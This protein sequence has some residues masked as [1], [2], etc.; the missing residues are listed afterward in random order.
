MF[1]T[2]GFTSVQRDPKVASHDVAAER[3]MGVV[4]AKRGDVRPLPSLPD[5]VVPQRFEHRAH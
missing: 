2:L 3:C 5:V 1:T 4:Y